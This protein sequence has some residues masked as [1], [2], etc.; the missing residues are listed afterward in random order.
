VKKSQAKSASKKAVKKSAPKK[1]VKKAAAKKAIKKA[2]KKVVKKSAPKKVVKSAKK[3]VKKVVKK[4]DKRTA[5]PAKKVVA[6]AKVAAKKFVAK[7]A[8]KKVIKRVV[9]KKS[10]AKKAKTAINNTTSNV[11]DFMKDAGS[12]VIEKAS[13]KKNDENASTSAGHSDS[14]EKEIGSDEEEEERPFVK[15][16]THLK[17]GDLAPF[18]E[19]KDQDGKQ[20]NLASFPGKTIILYFYPKDDTPGCTATACSLRDEQHYLRDR[21]YA[22]VGVSADDQKSHAKFS[23]KYELNFPLLADVD[24]NIVKAYNVWGAKKFMGRISDGIIRT[25]FV[26][27]PSGIIGEVINNVDTKN[28]AQQILELERSN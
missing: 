22:V 10:T 28:H 3:V 8:P 13:P 24:L 17:A 4:V 20:V 21:Q 5:T 16:Y 25:T 11:S 14:S 2:I 18:F 26:I 19:G 23:A 1:A 7:A 6:K 27:T 12:N 9:A 15:H